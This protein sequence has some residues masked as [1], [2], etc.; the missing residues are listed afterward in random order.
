MTKSNASEIIRIAPSPT[1]LMAHTAALSKSIDKLNQAS[2]AI[3][4]C[5]RDDQYMAEIEA[6]IDDLQIV[7][8]RYRANQEQIMRGV[9]YQPTGT[10]HINQ[11]A[12]KSSKGGL[13]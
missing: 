13:S 2:M 9:T 3:A 5:A 1:Q 10:D 11:L 8:L 4:A 6:A 12:T 7:M